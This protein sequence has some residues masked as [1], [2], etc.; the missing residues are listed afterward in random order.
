VKRHPQLKIG[1]VKD[2][3]GARVRLAHEGPTRDP[4]RF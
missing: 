3:D 4:M 2:S 1:S